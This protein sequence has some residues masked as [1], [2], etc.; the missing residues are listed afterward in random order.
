MVPPYG[1]PFML[2]LALQSD[3][4]LKCT[5][6]IDNLCYIIVVLVSYRARYNLLYNSL[7]KMANVGKALAQSLKV[8]IDPAN[9]TVSEPDPRN[10]TAVQRSEAPS[11]H[12]RG[13]LA[14]LVRY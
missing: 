8:A 4:V 10:E 1:V 12:V 5:R 2:P 6:F 7:T 14:H 3:M 13:L 9:T 11:N